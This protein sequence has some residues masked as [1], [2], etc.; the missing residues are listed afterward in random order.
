MEKEALQVTIEGLDGSLKA[1]YFDIDGNQLDSIEGYHVVSYDDESYWEMPTATK[2]DVRAAEDTGLL[3]GKDDGRARSL[4]ERG[5]NDAVGTRSTMGELGF[6]NNFGYTKDGFFSGLVEKGAGVLGLG[7]VGMGAK[8]ARNASNAA[9][10]NSARSA[11]GLGKKDNVASMVAGRAD[12]GEVAAVEIDGQQY[13]IRF[14]DKIVD[15][16]FTITP[17]EAQEL[18]KTKGPLKEIEPSV[19]AKPDPSRKGK[20]VVAGALDTVKGALG[21]GKKEDKAPE[22]TTPS[23]ATPQQ[24]TEV[25]PT[26]RD[27]LSPMEKM[28]GIEKGWAKRALDDVFGV[29]REDKV[30]QKAQPSI[31][32]QPSV[33][34][35]PDPAAPTSTSSF[36]GG[37]A[38]TSPGV[39]IDPVSPSK[40]RN[41]MPNTG[42]MNSLEAAA[43]A[44]FPGRDVSIS[45]TSGTYSPEKKG[46]IEKARAQAYADAKSKGYSNAQASRAADRAGKAA[47]QVGS[48][49]HTTGDAV[50]AAISI[51]G[52]PATP[53]EMAEIGQHFAAQNPE[54][55]NVGYA[56]SGYMGS[57]VA[58]FDETGY[59]TRGL[60]AATW[61]GKG[62][63][64]SAMRE[65]IGAVKEGFAP[66]SFTRAPTPTTPAQTPAAKEIDPLGNFAKEREVDF[67]LNPNVGPVGVDAGMYS[68][69]R[70][71]LPDITASINPQ[72]EA[73]GQLAASADQ[74]LAN[75]S[76]ASRSFN[77][78]VS[79]AEMSPARAASLGLMSRTE[80]EL[81]S[82]AMAIAGELGPES[83]ANLGSP[84]V[85][86]EIANYATTMENRAASRAW[87][88]TMSATLS[89]SQYNSLAPSNMSVTQQNYSKYGTAIKASLADF[90][91]GKVAPSNYGLTNMYAADPKTMNSVAGKATPGWAK[92]MSDVETVG[93]HV[94]GSLM[95]ST[96]DQTYQP[97]QAY[98]DL[99]ATWGTAQTGIS[100][101]TANNA[102]E[103][104]AKAAR[105]AAE[106]A[107]KDKADSERSGG[108]GAGSG[109]GD[110]GGFGG[111]FA[112]G[113][114]GSSTSKSSSSSLGSGYSSPASKSGQNYGGIAS[115][116]GSP[117]NDGN[118]KSKSPG[119]GF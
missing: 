41:A 71:P 101:V 99:A 75:P 19:D 23:L 69:E 10:V 53:T 104:A 72:K 97:G 20:G 6:G 89:P 13:S 98:R 74:A 110:S 12:T 76:V 27:D 25:T 78:D 106:K 112:S 9:S 38:R 81:D 108:Y 86:K 39:S 40:G 63:M 50:D 49:R 102:A 100:A 60:G 16:R 82:M 24:T 54:L 57:N 7:I 83:L 59:D 84:E 11:L 45:V 17:E 2:S 42:L 113:L 93:G 62:T 35:T 68:V 31:A 61:G 30:E 14:D 80:K 94:F 88:P 46:A 90:Y 64:P 109:R 67:S 79:W 36:A 95:N 56:P 118:G 116:G 87:G 111:G 15:D 44:A 115:V 52:K 26:P 117:T 47:G 66:L 51:D 33:S 48:T 43:Q 37:L 4:L 22:E 1:A 21:F 73:F 29:K 58:H 114:S 77:P 8:A 18:A 92:E 5:G 85:Q 105:D 103:A 34:T 55:S 96:I 119:G 91:S 28:T 32:T 3:L 70:A 107:E 65:S